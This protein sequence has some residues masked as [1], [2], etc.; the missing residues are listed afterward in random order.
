MPEAEKPSLSQVPSGLQ[1]YN[2]GHCSTALQDVSTPLGHQSQV[3]DHHPGV[4]NQVSAADSDSLATCRADPKW[5]S[6]PTLSMEISLQPYYPEPGGSV[7]Q[8]GFS[9]ESE[10]GGQEQ[11]KRTFEQCGGKGC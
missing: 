9:K 1:V 7:S 2:L 4:T 5:I 8:T 11:S 10:F 3:T 6:F